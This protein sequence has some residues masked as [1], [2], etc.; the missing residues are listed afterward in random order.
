MTYTR[1]FE[2]S[3]DSL[4]KD[5][6]PTEHD[7]IGAILGT[8]DLNS[9]PIA[10]SVKDSGRGDQPEFQGFYKFMK[11]LNKKVKERFKC[12]ILNTFLTFHKDSAQYLQTS[13]RD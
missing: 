13:V 6:L 2:L 8:K 3:V 7:I 11:K 5:S 10:I 4:D 9:L 1:Y 12:L